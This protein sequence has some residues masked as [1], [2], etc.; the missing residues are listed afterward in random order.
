MSKE[1]ELNARL[2]AL[3]ER[4]EKLEHALFS[5]VTVGSSGA[6]TKKTSAR[7]F[8]MLKQLKTDTQKVLA[9]GYFLERI[10][11]MESFNIKDLEKIFHAAKER[12]PKNLNDAVNKNIARGFVMNAQQKKDSMK[13]WCLTNTGESYVETD[14]HRQGQ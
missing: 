10:E 9:L 4:V 14:L 12:P 13:A 2:E 6:R 7:E 8:L 3:Q 11:G 1:S 5:S